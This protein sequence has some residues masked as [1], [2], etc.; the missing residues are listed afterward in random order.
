ME[1]RNN[2]DWIRDY[3]SG[4]L[5]P[6]EAIN[7]EKKIES[8]SK[9]KE[10]Y[11][12]ERLIYLGAVKNADKR[13]KNAMLKARK[14]V[15]ELEEDLFLD[16]TPDDTFV[17]IDIEPVFS[18]E[19]LLKMFQPFTQYENKILSVQR[20]SA[21]EQKTID[22]KS[23][24]N[25]FEPIVYLNV[26]WGTITEEPIKLSILNNQDETI[27]SSTLE[28]TKTVKIDVSTFRPGC[29]Y[30]KLRSK[31]YSMELRRFFIKKHLSPKNS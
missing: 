1:K 11:V 27:F 21:I 6:T 13:S 9:L 3:L 16:T 23:P 28:N 12:S 25:D 8:D 15:N 14:L 10:L 7:L 4:K 22:L 30:L 31:G 20:T 5:S 26:K 17:D 24:E 2:I 29:Y 19:E 18:L